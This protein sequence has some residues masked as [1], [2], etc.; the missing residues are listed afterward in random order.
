MLMLAAMLGGP[1]VPSRAAAGTAADDLKQIEYRYYFRGKYPEAVDALRTF[2]ARVDLSP[3]EQTR[4]R[5][6]LAAS[7]V[8]GGSPDRGR[9]VF[10]E[11][12]TA[13]PAY[14]GPDPAVFKADV[15]SA[16]TATRAE[17]AASRLREAPATTTVPSVTS[18]LA[19]PPPAR[20]KPVYR[21][22]W[23]YAGAAAVAAVAV[24]V[25]SSGGDDGGSSADTGTL[26]IGVNV[27]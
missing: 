22:W 16:Y 23:F 6:F 20:G 11:I 17:Y 8:L 18:G 27:R 4:A 7:H 21:Q 24:G 10:L 19:E 12:I 25:A 1:L 13:D 2:L 9:A 26:V 5:E 3:A 15:V 14:A